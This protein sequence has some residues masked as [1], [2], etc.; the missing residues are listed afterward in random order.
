MVAISLPAAILFIEWYAG[1]GC[2][3]ILAAVAFCL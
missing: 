2:I 1:L 3:K